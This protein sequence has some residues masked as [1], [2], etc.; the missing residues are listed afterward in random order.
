MQ[1]YFEDGCKYIKVP[2][3]GDC[4]LIK[5]SDAKHIFNSIYPEFI[6]DFRASKYDLSQGLESYMQ[7]YQGIVEALTTD[8][9]DGGYILARLISEVFYDFQLLTKRKRILKREH[10]KLE[11]ETKLIEY[12]FC[13]AYCGERSVTL[14]KDHVIP[15][16][17]GGTDK[18]KNIVPACR[19]CNA[20]KY[21]HILK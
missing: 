21:N 7:V 4:F 19:K 8:E 14:E 12:N 20:S 5:Y 15:V 11:W 9:D 3:A 2:G 10:S 6:S 1:I 16:S 13:C 18:I 17:K